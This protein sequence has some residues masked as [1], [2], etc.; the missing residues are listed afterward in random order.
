MIVYIALNVIIQGLVQ[1]RF[2][3][4]AVGLTAFVAFLSLIFWAFLLGGL[5]ALLAVPATLFVKLVLIDHAP[6]GP[7]ARDHRQLHGSR[8]RQQLMT[9][10]PW[11]PPSPLAS[12]TC[13]QTTPPCRLDTKQH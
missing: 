12:G 10:P 1:P 4:D 7:L 2:T 6:S 3:G 9:L 5:G 11:S 13:P 8:T